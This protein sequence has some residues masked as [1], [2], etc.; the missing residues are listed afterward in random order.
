MLQRNSSAHSHE[1]PV[2]KVGS[3]AAERDAWDVDC[4]S[5]SAAEQT[6]VGHDRLGPPSPQLQWGQ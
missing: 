3:V 5:Y 6:E 4:S 1:V 2:W